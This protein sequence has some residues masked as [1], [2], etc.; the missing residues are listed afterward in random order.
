MRLRS[1]GRSC[2]VRTHGDHVIPTCIGEASGRLWCRSH[3]T[4]LTFCTGGSA[5]CTLPVWPAV[6]CKVCLIACRVS[7]ITTTSGASAQR[8]LGPRPGRITACSGG[9]RWSGRGSAVACLR[10]R[11]HWYL[12]SIHAGSA[13]KL[14]LFWAVLCC[15]RRSAMVIISLSLSLS[16]SL[17]S[18][19]LS[20]FLSLS[21]SFSLS[22]SFSLQTRDVQQW[23]NKDHKGSK[24]SRSDSDSLWGSLGKRQC[25]ASF[26]TRCNRGTGSW[27]PLFTGLCHVYLALMK[28]FLLPDSYGHILSYLYPIYIWNILEYANNCHVVF[29]KKCVPGWCLAS[30]P[31]ES[32]LRLRLTPCCK[33]HVANVSAS[34]NRERTPT[35]THVYVCIYIYIMS[36]NLD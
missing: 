32:C 29:K 25:T 18:L 11:R 16:L 5:W 35:H 8:T 36:S 28:R 26:P 15:A 30:R 19:S 7:C 24:F 34:C 17:F 3:L 2:T 33:R 21:L 13:K 12:H 4:R 1:P 27:A 20:L 22:V 23:S 14:L 6:G 10:A 31:L 9:T